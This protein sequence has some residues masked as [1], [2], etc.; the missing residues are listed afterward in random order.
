MDAQVG[1]PTVESVARTALEICELD[2]RQ[3]FDSGK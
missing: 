3:G 1:L 2:D